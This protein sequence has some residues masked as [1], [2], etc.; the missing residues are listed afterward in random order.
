MYRKLRIILC[1]LLAIQSGI[2]LNA[3][4]SMDFLK[5]LKPVIT[6]IW[7]ITPGSGIID[8]QEVTLVTSATKIGA[9]TGVRAKFN[10]LKQKH[11]LET[12][13]DLQYQPQTIK[14][15]D[16]ASLIAGERDFKMVLVKIPVFYNYCFLKGETGHNRLGV[17][18]GTNFAFMPYK[19]IT[20]KG[21]LPE[22]STKNSFNEMTFG[23]SY[24]PVN[25]KL[26]ILLEAG[27]GT[28]PFYEDV[29]HQYKEKEIGAWSGLSLGL[30]VKY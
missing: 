1:L 6:Q 12:G 27:R 19:K 10:L 13:I 17:K 24:Y 9:K 5:N 11:F 2:Y 8:N 15:N 3:N 23:I 14:F 29:Y 18:I 20:D 28:S 4:T 16:Q 25:D 26:G 7:M 30:N 22:Y 21:N